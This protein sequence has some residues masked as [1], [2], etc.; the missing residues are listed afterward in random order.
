MDKRVFTL[1][2]ATIISAFILVLVIIYATNADSINKMLGRSGNKQDA[3]AE[4]STAVEE[5]TEYGQQIGDNLS[6]FMYDEDFFDETEKV[7]SVVVIKQSSASKNKSSDEETSEEEEQAGT[8]MAV[9]GQISNPD[10]APAVDEN[11]YLTS[12]PTP[13]PGGFGEYIPNTGNNT[14]VGT[15]P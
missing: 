1:T 9:V 4:S 7:P 12:V 13:P 8:G 3:A 15:M 5:I 14:I 10:A 6:G 2:I 11:G